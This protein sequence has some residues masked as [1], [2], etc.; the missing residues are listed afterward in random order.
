MWFMMSFSDKDDEPSGSTTHSKL[1]AKT[2]QV[3]D[4]S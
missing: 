3:S 2:P 1:I 4:V